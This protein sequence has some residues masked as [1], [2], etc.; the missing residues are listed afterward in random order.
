MNTKQRGEG[1]HNLLENFYTSYIR[2]GGGGRKE[3]GFER[4]FLM[5]GGNK[6]IF[7]IPRVD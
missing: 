1:P 3:N 2:G 6:N 7:Q 4:K 5:N